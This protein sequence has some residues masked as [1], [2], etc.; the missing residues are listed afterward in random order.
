MN[1]YGKL[2]KNNFKKE[3]YWNV[4][5]TNFTKCF[6]IKIENM[7]KIQFIK[8]LKQHGWHTKNKQWYCGDC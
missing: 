4:T 1:N 5:C 2:W 7:P 6:G 3:T 8:Y